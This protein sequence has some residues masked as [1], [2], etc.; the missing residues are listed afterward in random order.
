[1][2][3]FVFVYDPENTRKIIFQ[4]SFEITQG[5]DMCESRARG[6][7]T[8]MN[9]NGRIV[10]VTAGGIS[11]SVELLDPLANDGWI[12]GKTKKSVIP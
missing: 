8:K 11:D 4:N 10:I 2:L 7:C 6:S 12:P 5:P 3:P 9:L 1:M